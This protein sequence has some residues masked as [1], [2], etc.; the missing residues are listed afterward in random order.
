[1]GLNGDVRPASQPPPPPMRWMRPNV[2]GSRPSP[3]YFHAM[4]AIGDAVVIFGGK[5]DHSRFT[6]VHVFNKEPRRALWTQPHIRGMAPKPRSAH[7]INVVGMRI[8]VFGGHRDGEKFNDIHILDTTSM[9]WSCPKT[10][11]VPPGKRNAHATATHKDSLMIFGGFDGESCNDLHV[12]D[13]RTLTWTQ[14]NCRGEAPP[15]RCCHTFTL[16]ADRLWVFAGKNNDSGGVIERYND[17]ISLEPESFTWSNH[18]SRVT[19]AVP[20]RRNAHTAC[21][22]KH[23][24]L[25]FGGFDGDSCN[26]LYLFNTETYFWEEIFSQSVAPS[27]RYCHCAVSYPTTEGAWTVLVFGGCDSDHNYSDIQ[28]L[29]IGGNT[30]IAQK[31]C[32]LEAETKRL[33]AIVDAQQD[34]INTLKSKLEQLDNLSS[35]KGNEDNVSDDE[36]EEAET[37]SR[38]KKKKKGKHRRRK[39]SSDNDDYASPP[40]GEAGFFDDKADTQQ[41]NPYGTGRMQQPRPPAHLA[42]LN[43][44]RLP[45]QKPL[46]PLDASPPQPNSY[47]TYATL[48]RG[49]ERRSNKHVG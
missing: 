39:K 4:T 34:T 11:G 48:L 47:P 31:S 30:N 36:D 44:G 46:N 41:S 14:P 16:V 15:R 12:F 3:R 9:S 10:K 27:A 2:K 42:P 8:Y 18:A 29:E 20:S 23:Y 43:M 1:M 32:E 21:A 28:Q 19:G 7:S 40:E 22:Y 25:I 6:D 26:D 17:I 45:Q 5:D 33:Q 37:R 24:L 13:T 35:T 38:K 49:K